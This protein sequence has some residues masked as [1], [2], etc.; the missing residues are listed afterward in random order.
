M[1]LVQKFLARLQPGYEKLTQ[2]EQQW[3][4]EVEKDMTH[5]RCWLMNLMDGGSAN[6]KAEMYP[7]TATT[8]EDCCEFHFK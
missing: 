3:P 5:P 8:T 1:K 2:A 6:S 4:Y 7:E